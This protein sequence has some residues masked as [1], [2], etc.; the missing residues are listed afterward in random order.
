MLF[1]EL[2][3]IS[4]SQRTEPNPNIPKE[5]AV[6]SCPACVRIFTSLSRLKD[7]QISH[8][9]APSL[10]ICDTCGQSFKYARN[11]R[12]HLKIHTGTKNFVCETCKKEFM[13]NADLT[14]HEKTHLGIK[15]FLC[16]I[17]SKSFT[18]PLSLTQHLRIHNGELPFS[19]TKC[20]KAY[21]NKSSLEY[22]MK[23]SHKNAVDFSSPNNSIQDVSV[24]VN[25]HT[26]LFE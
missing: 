15:L 20:Q 4:Q 6:F 21:H 23:T 14:R 7:H 2:R 13:R 10:F 12:R 1:L 5:E 11:L 25:P 3:E 26:N 19:C 24:N 9:P 16:E 22:H 17:C 18:R 8:L